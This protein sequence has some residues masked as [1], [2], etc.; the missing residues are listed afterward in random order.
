[1]FSKFPK[2]NIK[3][4]EFKEFIN[5]TESVYDDTCSFLGIKTSRIK[6]FEAKNVSKIN[7]EFNIET[8]IQL[9]AFFEPHNKKLFKLIGTEYNWD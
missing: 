2:K 1:M 8:R 4:I 5:N 9:K 7:I 6:S 3:I